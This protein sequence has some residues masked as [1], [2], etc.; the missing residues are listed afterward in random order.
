MLSRFD[1]IL[2]DNH[3]FIVGDTFNSNDEHDKYALYYENEVFK[4]ITL[5]EKLCEYFIN[6]ISVMIA[7][8]YGKYSTEIINEIIGN[9]CPYCGTKEAV[10]KI[11]TLYISS[12]EYYFTL[13]VSK[14]CKQ[15]TFHCVTSDEIGIIKII[16]YSQYGSDSEWLKIID[17]DKKTNEYKVNFNNERFLTRIIANINGIVRTT[18]FFPTLSEN[19]LKKNIYHLSNTYIDG[20]NDDDEVNIINANYFYD[21]KAINQNNNYDT[22][23][24]FDKSFLFI[25]KDAFLENCN[26]LTQLVDKINNM[27]NITISKKSKSLTDLLIENS[28]VTD[29]ILFLYIRPKRRN[30]VTIINDE[31]F[32]NLQLNLKMIHDLNEMIFDS[33]LRDGRII[34]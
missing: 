14:I 33:S 13:P 28:Q 10:L 1:L 16:F 11:K 34:D 32:Y 4:Y 23:L 6:D 29:L 5:F 27:E 7:L 20:F 26:I 9:E 15:H 8:Y 19:K 22:A 21:S 17:I 24:L 31:F 2:K 25:N 3:K 30:V 18:D 12:H